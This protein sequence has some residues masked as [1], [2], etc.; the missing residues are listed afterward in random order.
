MTRNKENKTMSAVDLVLLGLVQETPRSAYEVQKQVEFR[1]LSRW[2]KISS[3]S[4][5]KKLIQ[6]EEKGYL[7]GEAFREGKMPE[8]IVYSI[9]PCGREYFL[10]LMKFHAADTVQVLFDFNAVIANLNKIPKEDAMEL[11]DNIRTGMTESKKYMEGVLPHRSEIPLV[12]RT[13][14]IQ[15][16]EVLRSLLDWIDSFQ[17]EFQEDRYP[18]KKE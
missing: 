2:V 10:K 13:I 17:A 14:M 6:L 16:I 5:Y 12:G 18:A 7:T 4:V 3:P 1:N 8:K 9:T 11:I 15:Q